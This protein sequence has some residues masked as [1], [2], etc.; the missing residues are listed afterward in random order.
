MHE[1]LGIDGPVAGLKTSTLLLATLGSCLLERIRAN[2]TIGNIEIT[3]LVLEVE[4][5]LA[6]SPLWDKSGQEPNPVGFEAIQVRVHIDADAPDPAL[7]ALIE[8]AMIWS[9]VANTLHTPIHLDVSLVPKLV[10]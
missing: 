9:P 2:A 7:Q 1:A 6:M 10:S 5:E 8:H 4:A 3:K